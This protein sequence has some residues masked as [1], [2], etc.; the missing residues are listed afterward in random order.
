MEKLK[1][2]T[3][4]EVAYKICPV[5]ALVFSFLVTVTTLYLNESLSLPFIFISI[6]VYL[7][8][9]SIYAVSNNATTMRDNY[10]NNERISSVVIRITDEEDSALKLKY[11]YCEKC[12]HYTCRPT[13]HCRACKK[14]F[15]FRDH[16]CF[17]IGG[18]ILEPNMGNFILIC[19]HTS[20]A[21]IY[22]STIIGPY[23]YESLSEVI[24]ENSTTFTVFLNFCFPV[25][26]AR[27]LITGQGSCLL[28]VVL[29]DTLI[30]VSIACFLYGSWKL[31]SCL[32]G[33]QRYYPHIARKQE[34]K[35]IFGSYGAWN[36]IFPYNGLLRGQ[37]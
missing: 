33:K 4:Y 16:H 5:L 2:G 9:Y 37:Y 21:C 6:Q 19:F 13:Q 32:S 3:F 22:S 23:I 35:E 11:W 27:F 28:F 34:L 26:L 7:N 31:F 15:H 12:A 30:S 36:L 8:W 20:L 10:T 24:G 25:A 18:C 14:C 1:P 17:F 29:F